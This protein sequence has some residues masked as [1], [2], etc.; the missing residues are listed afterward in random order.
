[1]GEKYAVMTSAKR[2]RGAVKNLQNEVDRELEKY[3]NDVDLSKSKQNIYLR[4]SDN[5]NRDITRLLKEKN[6]KEM[7]DNTVLIT[8]VYSF[9][10]EWYKDNVKTFGKAKAD[11][12]MLDYFKDCLAFEEKKRGICISAVIHLDE[13]TPH[14]HCAS[15]PIVESPVRESVACTDEKGEYV[16]YANGKIKY[17]YVPKFDDNGKPLMK[18]SLNASAVFGNKVKMSKT[19]TEF[20]KECGVKY[21]LQ[22]GE[23]RIYT[24]E[25]VK[26]LEEEDFKMKKRQDEL[27]AYALELSKQARLI[28][29]QRKK[30]EQDE[31]DREERIK[32]ENKKIEERRDKEKKAHEK[33]INDLKK[34]Y[35][36][37]EA[38][39]LKDEKKFE[40]NI[41]S[42]RNE[43]R[44]LRTENEALRRNC[45]NI[46][47]F[48]DNANAEIRK[49]VDASKDVLDDIK[50]LFDNAFSN[51][52]SA[53]SDYIGRKEDKVLDEKIQ[54]FEGYT[55]VES[56]IRELIEK[57]LK[58]SLEKEEISKAAKS[59]LFDYTKNIP[60]VKL[61]D[62]KSDVF[63]KSRAENDYS[64]IIFVE[65]KPKDDY[66]PEF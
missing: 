7:K 13:T 29:E 18:T 63:D 54:Y 28:E 17:K 66:G 50:K 40:K 23:M 51:I 35:D 59:S 62:K 58:M 44:S 14:M 49:N 46:S 52:L 30:L 2:K 3:K 26:H 4:K 60:D 8:T 48:I 37:L 15:V 33:K 47:T 56:T 65:E 20:V 45:D 19:Q 53:V 27:N 5:W 39:Y 12:I 31:K 38:K 61:I 64:R 55:A 9:S 36:D 57:R 11:E 41:E 10:P 42:A 21:G 1:M 32:K 34:K 25:K 6:L 22:R 24:D 43:V 16:R